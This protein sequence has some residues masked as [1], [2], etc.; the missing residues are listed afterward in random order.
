VGRVPKIGLYL[1]FL[2]SRSDLTPHTSGAEDTTQHS[3]VEWAADNCRGWWAIYTADN[4]LCLSLIYNNLTTST[5]EELF[6][7]T[8]GARSVAYLSLVFSRNCT[9]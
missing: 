6:D 7:L 3:R 2:R 8:R 1:L 5:P 4:I 9:V